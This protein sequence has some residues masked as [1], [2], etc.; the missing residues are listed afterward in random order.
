MNAENFKQVFLPLH[1]KL[2]RIAYRLLEN[3]NDAQDII[4]EVYMKLWMI[5]D[6]C[7][8]IQNTEAY[9]VTLVK[10]LCLTQ[11][12]KA[13]HRFRHEGTE[14][15]NM[16]DTGISPDIYLETKDDLIQIKRL[17]DQMPGQQKEVMILK[18]FRGCSNEEIEQITGLSN[19]NIRTMLSRGRKKIKELFKA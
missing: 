13:Y 6:E 1:S 14:Q 11:L 12:N 8:D 7:T 10:N 2:Y 4:Q 15:L 9:C 16:A 17:I 18:H 5:R 19:G 3:Q